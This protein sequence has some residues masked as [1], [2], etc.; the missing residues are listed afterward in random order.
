MR[1]A[2]TWASWRDEVEEVII[3]IVLGKRDLREEVSGLE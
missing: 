2:R 1:S 3:L